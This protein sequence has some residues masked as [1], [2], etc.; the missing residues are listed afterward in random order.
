LQ[1]GPP[2]PKLPLARAR[3]EHAIA[4]PREA[5]LTPLAESLEIHRRHLERE[6]DAVQERSG[7]L[8]R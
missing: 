1:D 3:R 4:D 8:A 2:R 6:V 7:H 5:L